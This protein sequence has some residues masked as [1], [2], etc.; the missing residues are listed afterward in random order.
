MEEHDQVAMALDRLDLSGF[1]VVKTRIEDEELVLLVD[2]G[3]QGTKKYR[4]SLA[5][6]TPPVVEAAPVV[7]EPEPEPAPAPKRTPARRKK[8]G[9]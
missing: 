7:V 1:P 2:Q 4:V 3:I 6:L 9:G 5:D 8:A